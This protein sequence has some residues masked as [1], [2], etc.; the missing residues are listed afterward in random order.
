VGRRLFAQEPLRV[1]LYVS[2]YYRWS[3]GK[4]EYVYLR[5]ND[6]ST[7]L[8]RD[9]TDSEDYS[10]SLGVRPT[11]RIHERVTVE[12]RFALT[13]GWF[14]S[15]SVS[16]DWERDGDGVLERYSRNT[17]ERSGDTFRDSG[18]NT[19]SSVRFAFWF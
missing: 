14:W 1:E 5:S 9:M 19:L 12:T 10:I 16:E 15:R 4:N 3:H 2:G 6:G 13:Y 8:N 17:R 7:R 18:V 11:Y